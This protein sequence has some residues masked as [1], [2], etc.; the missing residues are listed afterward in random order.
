L[1][2]SSPA[3]VG[4]LFLIV[5]G[6]QRDL[7]LLVN[8]FTLHNGRGDLELF[9]LWLLRRLDDMCILFACRCRRSLRILLTSLFS[10]L[11]FFT[12]EL[13]VADNL[14]NPLRCRNRVQQ[15][16]TSSLLRLRLHGFL[17]ELDLQTVQLGL[18]VHQLLP[19]LLYNMLRDGFLQ[20]V[21]ELC[22]LFDVGWI[23][24][25]KQVV[26]QGQIFVHFLNNDWTVRV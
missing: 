23:F 11:G 2:L 15:R 17:L 16:L 12:E 22:Q 8:R 9:L 1:V 24:G 20:N 5:H 10:R 25:D 4:L 13:R 7:T 19:V 14:L 26:H 21:L 3:F 6:N 18:Q